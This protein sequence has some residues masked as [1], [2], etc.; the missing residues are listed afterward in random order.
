MIKTKLITEKLASH[1]RTGATVRT[2]LFVD[3]S[4]TI[5]IYKASCCRDFPYPRTIYNSVSYDKNN[6]VQI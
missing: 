3:S 2:G 5:N 4:P 6:E 1:V